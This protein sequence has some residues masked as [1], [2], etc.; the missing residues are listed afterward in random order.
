MTNIPVISLECFF[1]HCLII[2]QFI[3]SQKR[4]SIN[5]LQRIIFLITQPI[6]CRM[7][8]YFKSFY[9]ACF[10]NVGT[11]AKIYKITNFINTGE[12]ILW[13]LFFYEFSFEFI[14]RKQFKCLI[15]RYFKTLKFMILFNYLTNL[16]LNIFIMIFSYFGLCLKVIEKAFF[17]SWT[18]RHQAIIIN[19]FYSCSKDMS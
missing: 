6:S 1:L 5:S 8:S 18:H 19:L 7:F 12:S 3:F 2:F 10:S 14:I 11:S 17:N 9:L 4:Y 15:L 16:L 13:D